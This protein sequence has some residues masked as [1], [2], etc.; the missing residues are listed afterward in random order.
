MLIYLAVTGQGHRRES[1]AAMFW[2]ESDT[3]HAKAA[4]RRTLSSLRKALGGEW[5]EI[6]RARLAVQPPWL[7]TRA[8]AE[9]LESTHGH[10][11]SAAESCA[12]CIEPLT[13][14]LELY[15]G[16][17]MAGFTLP[18]S[19]QFDEWQY[20]TEQTLLRKYT[21][22]LQRLAAAHQSVG[23]FVQALEAAER[24][25]ASDP[26]NENAHRQLMRLYISLGRRDLAL[27]Q[28]RDCV[29]LLR[30]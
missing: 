7:D 30:A 22:A 15:R 19:P 28:Y 1:L 2:P 5:L 13:Q 20:F 24:L 29:R 27:K 4:L 12:R 3:G 9:L 26:L 11:H 8:F 18:D 23:S 10:G 6:D 25:L 16:N 14:A 17:F 21:E